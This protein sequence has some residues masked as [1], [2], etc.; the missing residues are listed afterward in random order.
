[1]T[2][3]ANCLNGIIKYPTTCIR[4]YVENNTIENWTLEYQ[5][6]G[7]SNSVF[8]G[9]LAKKSD[10]SEINNVINSGAVLTQN[11]LMTVYYNN[12][13]VYYLSDQKLSDNCILKVVQ[14]DEINVNFDFNY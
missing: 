9:K 7:S 14:K 6:T 10:V 12:N 1:M 11:D 13:N 2:E 4:A 8:F 5:Y 3:Y